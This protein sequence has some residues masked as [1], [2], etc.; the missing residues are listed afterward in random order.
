M[1]DPA[2]SLLFCSPDEE[3]FLCA[4]E[5]FGYKFSRR[6]H[7]TITIRINRPIDQL[8]F[9]RRTVAAPASALSGGTPLDGGTACEV[10]FRI[11]HVLAYSQVWAYPFSSFSNP[12][13]STECLLLLWC[14]SVNE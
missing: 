12:G 10:V 5:S 8:P 11:L 3:A 9:D 14:R 2:Q 7:E 4:T 13:V 1:V 6:T